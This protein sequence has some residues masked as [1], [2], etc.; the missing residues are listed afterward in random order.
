MGTP[1]EEED[2]GL[3]NLFEKIMTENFP[4]MVREKVMQILK[5][6]RVPI[7]M[8]QRGPLQDTS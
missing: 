7:K 8:I 5:A 2:Q 3:E 6:Q 4:T 1:E